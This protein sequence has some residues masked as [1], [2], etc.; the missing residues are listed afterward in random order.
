MKVLLE[1][2]GRQR[3][4]KEFLNNYGKVY[5]SVVAFSNDIGGEIIIGVS[6]SGKVLGLKEELVDKYLEELARSIYDAV[7]PACMPKI[8][9]R[10]IDD[11]T[12][13]EIIVYEGSK[14]PYFI[15]AQG[16]PDGVYIRVGAHNKLASKDILEELLLSGK[17][18]DFDETPVSEASIDDLDPL[19]LKEFYGSKS[20]SQ[21]Q[22]LADKVLVFNALSRQMELSVC[23]LVYFHKNPLEF[24]HGCEV[25]M[26]VFAGNTMGK[27][28][29]TSDISGPLPT[30]LAQVEAFLSPY[31][32]INYQKTGMKLKP[33]E[34]EISY[35]AL[36]EALVNAL[37]H[38][39][40]SIK[41]GVKIAVFDNRVE[42]FSPGNF[43]GPIT[44]EE[45]KSGMTYPRNESI[46]QLARKAGIVE[47]RGLGLKLIIESQLPNT[48]SPEIIEGSDYV[49]VVLYRKSAFAG[50]SLTDRFPE[51]LHALLPLLSE[52]SEFQT[53]DVCRVLHVSANTARKRIQKLIEL[54]LVEVSG[55]GRGSKFIFKH[56]L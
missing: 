20:Y 31:L 37:I 5:Q 26:T 32:Q 38:R 18:V 13:V 3:E 22:L 7:S 39:K 23:G 27:I 16:V 11:K 33:S 43:P 15:K 25:L 50:I 8:C 24:L 28:V 48:P 40:Y 56:R 12:V 55:Q 47:K 53:S 45:Y 14:K 10:N 19:V 34:W 2:E 21:K 17:R 29:K 44:A 1:K 36:R 52:R 46:R 6:D 49:K 42:I 9:T 30:L 51:E 41:S 54:G 4:Y 35:D